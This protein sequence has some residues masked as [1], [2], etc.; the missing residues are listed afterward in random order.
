MMHK[1]TLKL[2]LRKSSPGLSPPLSRGEICCL[3][4]LSSYPAPFIIFRNGVHSRFHGRSLYI[5][6][7][8]HLYELKLLSLET[9]RNIHGLTISVLGDNDFRLLFIPFILTEADIIRTV[10]EDY[11]I[12]ILLDGTGLTKVRKLRLPASSL[13]LNRLTGKLGK[14]NYRDI[15][16]LGR[17]LQCS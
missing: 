7:I 17:S 13:T 4:R 10:Y 1:P 5:N 3:V 14:G 12:G 11:H 6:G 16:F 8:I 2:F 15:E 9:H